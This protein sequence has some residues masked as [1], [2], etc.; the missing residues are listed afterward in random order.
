MYLH[1]KRPLVILFSPK[2]CKTSGKGGSK[3]GIGPKC[4]S[5]LIIQVNIYSVALLMRWWYI[6]SVNVW[7]FKGLEF[8][9]CNL[10]LCAAIG[11]K[12]N[13]I[14]VTCKILQLK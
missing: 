3:W 2:Q 4:T 14:S 13:L 11:E 1:L 7:F 5:K 8:L 10:D 12:S 9:F 6:K